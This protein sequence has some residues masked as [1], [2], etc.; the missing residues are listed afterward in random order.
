MNLNC[1]FMADTQGNSTSRSP[2]VII[3]GNYGATNIGDEAILDGIISLVRLA[4]PDAEITALSSNPEATEKLHGVKSVL[5]VPAGLRSF[6]QGIFQGTFGKTLRTIKDCDAFL[7]GGGGLFTDEKLKAVIIWY[8]QGLAARAYKKRLFMIGQS[9]GPLSTWL[10][11]KLSANTFQRAT[12]VTV[13]DTKSAGVLHDIN[14]PQ[15]QILADPAFALH[16]DLIPDMTR[17][18][19]VVWTVRPWTLKAGGVFDSSE[20]QY[21]E[22]AKFIDWLYEKHGL[23]SVLVPFQI[24][25]DHDE[26]VL[27]EILGMVKNPQSAEVFSYTEN[28]HELMELFSRATAV[29][30]MRLHSLIFSIM[31][32]TPFLAL[33]YSSKVKALLADAGMSDYVLT[34]GE[35]SFEDL[36]KHFEKLLENKERVMDTLGEAHILMSTNAR[37]HVDVLR[38]F[39]KVNKN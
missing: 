27:E 36:Q 3:C 26:K 34:W 19:Y 4:Y 31:S 15:P 32:Q 21:A 1:N 23:K 39:L 14:V 11:K 18:K 7:L 28:F 12:A 30:G 17:E 33:S 2:K 13:R 25:Q 20:K 37:K 38:D 5:M 6:F 10:G 8:L 24:H 22:C 16:T 35:T 29:V 9:V